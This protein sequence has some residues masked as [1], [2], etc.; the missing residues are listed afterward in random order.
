[1]RLS[2]W[3][4]QNKKTYDL[5]GSAFTNPDPIKQNLYVKKCNFYNI[6]DTLI[7]NHFQVND[8]TGRNNCL[9]SKALLKGYNALLTV[10]AFMNGK[11]DI[12]EVK[13]FV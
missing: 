5:Y 1:M 11:A 8:L 4:E 13:K 7:A 9:Y 2:D 3:R 6:D 12:V 10:Q